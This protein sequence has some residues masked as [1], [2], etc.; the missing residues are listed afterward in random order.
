MRT[1]LILVIWILLRSLPISGCKTIKIYQVP[2]CLR[3]NT[4]WCM[5]QTCWSGSYI[6]HHVLF[7]WNGSLSGMLIIQTVKIFYYGSWE[8]F[9][10]FLSKVEYTWLT[11]HFTF[12]NMK[13]K[14]N[15][16][17]HSRKI[18]FFILPSLLNTWSFNWRLIIS[19]E[20][21]KVLYEIMIDLT[22][23]WLT[24]Q[25]HDDQTLD[26]WGIATCILFVLFFS[27]MADQWMV[28]R[29]TGIL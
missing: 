7:I 21:N 12:Q 20:Y 11:P 29:H 17:K 13:E 5:W 14:Q 2:V 24:S 27:G 3:E 6:F 22:R 8:P 19:Y 15:N 9:K 25:G 23:S 26:R 1:E 10:G 16:M 18:I 28:L 4:E